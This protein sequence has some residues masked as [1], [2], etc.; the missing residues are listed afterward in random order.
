VSQSKERRAQREN[1]F[2]DTAYVHLVT[3]TSCA[4]TSMNYM[5]L[6]NSSPLDVGSRKTL[7]SVLLFLSLSPSL[8][9]SFCLLILNLNV[10]YTART[11]DC[12]PI[13]FFL[14]KNSFKTWII[15]MQPKRER[16]IEKKI[17]DNEIQ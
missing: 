14:E 3:V 1:V 9:L 6:C 13:S 15:L 7:I 17:I 11:K 2:L 10:N 4:I 16:E 8:S 12:F 5:R